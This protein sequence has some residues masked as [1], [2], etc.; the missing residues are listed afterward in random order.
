MDSGGRLAG[1]VAAAHTLLIVILVQ[2][3]FIPNQGNALLLKENSGLDS[4]NVPIMFP[5]HK[6]LCCWNKTCSLSLS[7]S[8]SQVPACGNELLG[9]DPNICDKY[10]TDDTIK[11]FSSF[12]FLPGSGAHTTPLPPPHTLPSLFDHSR[13]LTGQGGSKRCYKMANASLDAVHASPTCACVRVNAS[14][15]FSRHDVFV[16]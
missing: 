10:L 5:N 12:L 9:V 15:I 8:V 3:S 2:C 11:F 16:D 14:R 6:C 4:L 7:L 13:A 1:V